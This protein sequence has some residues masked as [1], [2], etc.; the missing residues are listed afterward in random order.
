MVGVEGGCWDWARGRAPLRAPWHQHAS[1]NNSSYS[2]TTLFQ[3]K[4]ATQSPAL[5]RLEPYLFELGIRRILEVCNLL[6]AGLAQ[7]LGQGKARWEPL[8]SVGQELG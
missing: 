7:R 2:T 5:H 8:A 4:V 6:I 3:R 1:N